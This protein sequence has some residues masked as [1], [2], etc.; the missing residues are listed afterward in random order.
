M[1]SADIQQNEHFSQQDNN[2]NLKCG[3]VPSFV[4]SQKRKGSSTTE[5]ETTMSEP[6]SAIA[7]GIPRGD[8]M[9]HIQEQM[10]S[11]SLSPMLNT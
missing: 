11:L 10:N 3:L 5:I 4:D 6:D 2:G 1:N 9:R 7:S 8:G